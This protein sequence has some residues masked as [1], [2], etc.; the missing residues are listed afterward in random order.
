MPPTQT[1]GALLILRPLL[2]AMDRRLLRI[3][4]KLDVHET[5]HR[6]I[7]AKSRIRSE[8]LLQRVTVLEGNVQTRTLVGGLALFTGVV[9]EVW[10]RVGGV[11]P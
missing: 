2:E 4:E 10:T 9:V 8:S 7:E 3:E 5:Y 11:R 6:D 1:D